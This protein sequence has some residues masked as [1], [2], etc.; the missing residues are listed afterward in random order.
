MIVCIGEILVDMIGE[1]RDGAL[2]YRRC[3]GGAPFNVACA[4]KKTGA[5]SGFTG[6]AGD[7]LF[8]RYLRDYAQNVGFDYLDVKLDS[9]A[10]TTLAVVQLD[11]TGERSFCFCR[12]HTADYK[13]DAEQVQRAVSAASSVCLGTLMLSEEEGRKTADLIVSLAKR[14]KKRLCL[15]VNYREDIF[16]NK[17]AAASLYRKYI[18]AADI[19]KFSEEELAMFYE[20]TFEERLSAAAEGDK[21]VCVTLG[22]R[23][24][25]YAYRGKIG[26]AESVPVQ[27]VD[28]TGA[29]DAFFGCLLGQLDLCD[30][31]GLSSKQLES[32]M[33]RANL[34]GALT[35]CGLGAIDPIP[36]KEKL[37]EYTI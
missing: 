16:K 19:V 20:G 1:T 11:E 21:L 25:A 18:G 28:T 27:V 4:A 5:E 8:G 34:C 33:K 13:I 24:C 12:K 9:D 22:A 6:R 35:T 36:S 37:E 23:G 30:I 17:A 26:Y 31:Q 32:I 10:G 7:D 3:A 29:G 2:L 15:D 14:Q